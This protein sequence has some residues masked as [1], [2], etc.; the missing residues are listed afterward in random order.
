VGQ[1]F[2]FT[3]AVHAIGFVNEIFNLVD[4]AA[5]CAQQG[6]FWLKKFEGK[7]GRCLGQAMTSGSGCLRQKIPA[8]FGAD[9]QRLRW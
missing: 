9:K 7:R 4:H 3:R 6:A 2:S 8:Q 1:N 5:Y